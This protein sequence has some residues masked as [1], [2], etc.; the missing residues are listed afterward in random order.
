MKSMMSITQGEDA[1]GQELA[2]ALKDGI[3]VRIEQSFFFY[4]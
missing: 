2:L 4:F 3:N 1:Q